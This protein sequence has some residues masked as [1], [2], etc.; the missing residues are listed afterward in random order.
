MPRMARRVVWGLSLVMAT[1]SP[2]S[3]LV[4]VDLPTFGRPTKVTKPERKFSSVMCVILLQ[5]LD[6]PG[7]RMPVVHRFLDEHRGDPAAAAAGGSA[8]EQEPGDLGGGAGLRHA[9]QCLAQEP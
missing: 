9:P 2:T 7:T 4:S 1:F 5:R 6:L 3:A 8:G